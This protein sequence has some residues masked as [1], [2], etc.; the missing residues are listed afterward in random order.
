MEVSD[1]QQQSGVYVASLA[2]PTDD[3]CLLCPG[4]LAGATPFAIML[5]SMA[6]LSRQGAEM[7]ENAH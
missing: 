7:L 1:V 4:G 2:A 6:I 3:R 5:G